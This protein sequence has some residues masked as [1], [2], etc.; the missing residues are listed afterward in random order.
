MLIFLKT[1]LYRKLANY[2]QI[3]FGKVVVKPYQIA[4]LILFAD[5]L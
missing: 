1:F 4:P 2:F 3:P 5:N